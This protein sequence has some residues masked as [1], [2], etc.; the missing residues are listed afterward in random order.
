LAPSD[1]DSILPIEIR[2]NPYGKPWPM[3]KYNWLD[4]DDCQIDR[5]KP[6]TVNEMTL[7]Y[8]YKD[9][10]D[11]KQKIRHAAAHPTG[12]SRRANYAYDEDFNLFDG[13]SNDDADE[14]RK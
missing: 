11:L 13:M 9:V 5:I 1:L 7:Y 8:N 14:W 12:T 6:T 4:L 10:E 3:K 2:P